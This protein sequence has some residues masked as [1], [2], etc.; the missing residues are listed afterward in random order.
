MT[1]Y[2]TLLRGINVSGQKKIKMEDLRRLFDNLGFESVQSYIQS[3]NVIFRSTLSD[4]SVIASKIK[5]QINQKYGF[6]VPVLIRTQERLHKIIDNNPF[7]DK[8]LSK[9]S[10]LFLA[11]SPTII[12]TNEIINVKDDLEEFYF[13]NKEIYLFLPKG[14]G[15][16]KLTTNFFE[17][18]MKTSITARN[19]RTTT[20]LQEIADSL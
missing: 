15:R 4:L 19:W 14:A 8:D 5:H 10:I 12:P 2:I 9:V 13:S 1:V 16:T 20:K 18:K 3:G 11:E 6:E 7:F 17:R